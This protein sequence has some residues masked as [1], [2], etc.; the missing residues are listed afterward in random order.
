MAHLHSVDS[1]REPKQGV[2]W[3][4]DNG[5]F[6]AFNAGR[7]WSEEP[8][9][10]YLDQFAAWKPE[11]AVVPA[12]LAR[13]LERE[14]NQLIND[15][16]QPQLCDETIAKLTRERDRMMEALKV[17]YTWSAADSSSPQ[18]RSEAMWDIM[19]KA[20]AAI[21]ATKEGKG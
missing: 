13:R 12:S 4:L 15:A 7:E 8:F 11:W 18:K 9:Y 17:I 3:A 6:G 14:R 20:S 21:A 16:H 10:S 1:P 19:E 2:K 5:I